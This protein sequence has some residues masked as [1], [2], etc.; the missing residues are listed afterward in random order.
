MVEPRATS[1]SLGM[2][3]AI[4]V[5]LGYTVV[6]EAWDEPTTEGSV[7]GPDRQRTVEPGGAWACDE[8]AGRGGGAGAG[9]GGGGRRVLVHRGSAPGGASLGR[10]DRGV[11]GAV[12]SGGAGGG[13]AAP[14]G[15]REGQ[16][17]RRRAGADPGRG[18]SPTGPGAGPDGD[19]VAD[20]A[21]TGVAE[22]RGWAAR[23]QHVHHLVRV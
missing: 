17:R 12:Q 10:R 20:D 23:G 1:G 4:P 15:R 7:A 22:R 5:K 3:V 21:A 14:R 9:V 13:R 16:V 6:R 19:L 18:A 2:A 11:G 8:R